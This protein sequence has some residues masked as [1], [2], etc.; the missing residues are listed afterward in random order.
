[1][2]E[3]LNPRLENIPLELQ[4]LPQWVLWRGTWTTTK[5]GVRKITKVPYSTRLRKAST[6]DP[7]TWTTFERVVRALP[8]ALDAW[9][10]DAPESP[11]GGIGFVFTA[12]DPYAG[13]DLDHAVGEDGVASWA[14]DIV[15][16]LDT[17]AE[18][19]ISGTGIHCLCRGNWPTGRNRKDHVEVYCQ[20]RFFTMS[21]HVLASGMPGGLLPDRT[22]ALRALH[23]Q[24]FPPK[25]PKPPR[26]PRVALPVTLTE[27][28]ILHKARVARNGPKFTALFAGETAG[29]GSASEA[30]AALCAMLAFWTQDHDQIDALF[31]QSGLYREKWD[32]RRGAERTY[33]SMTIQHALDNLGERFT[34]HQRHPSSPLSAPVPQMYHNTTDFPEDDG[35]PPPWEGNGTTA[36]A[37]TEIPYTPQPTPSAHQVRTLADATLRLNKSGNPYA[38]PGNFDVVLRHYPPWRG[39]LWW[40]AFRQIAM[41]GDIPIT[42][43]WLTRLATWCGQQ[44]GISVSQMD[45]LRRCVHAVARDTTRD[46]LIDYLQSLAWDGE[47]RL[48]T[49]L[50]RYGGAQDTPANAWIGTALLCAMAARGLHPGCIQRLVVIFEGAENIG[51]ST[52]VRALGGDYTRVLDRTLDTKDAILLLRGCWVMEVPE[53]DSFGRSEESRVKAFVT[54]TTDAV[55]LKFDNDVSEFQRRCVLIA[56]VNPTGPYLKSQTGNTRFLP[57]ALDT[58]DLTGFYA[59]REQLL[60]EAVAMV[61]SG[62]AWWDE[63]ADA[64]LP[65]VREARRESDVY[66][67]LVE[68]YLEEHCYDSYVLM[69]DI[70]RYGLSIE[71]PERWK[72]RA[73]TTRIG[74]IIYRLGWSRKQV[75]D[76]QKRFSA[77]FS[78]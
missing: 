24:L 2:T 5:E 52:L 72:D 50:A 37:D 73:L 65:D 59:V 6:T 71:Q 75:R 47:K 62:V 55:I 20:E 68:K 45:L 27:T 12:D 63:P 33:G 53:Y 69:Q 16:L 40:D 9:G 70:L 78:R 60:A 3:V 30:D 42:D 54:T 36:C 34:P 10:E 58:V 44:L 21:G 67:P 57:V 51:K 32:T 11:G 66:E 23:A 13:V 43:D 28:E 77:Y 56:T 1:M 29:Y 35:S 19:S 15:R 22:E 14:D 61:H 49:W 38:D 39:R 4:V 25:M 31:R 76:G 46:P 74:T 17:Y 64:L 18:Y 48:H 41:D 26:P 8:V 7:Q